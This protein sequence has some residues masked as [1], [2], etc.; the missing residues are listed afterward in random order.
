M[1]AIK[2]SCDTG[3]NP[4]D[5]AALDIGLDMHG[6]TISLPLRIVHDTGVFVAEGLAQLPPPLAGHL[7]LIQRVLVAFA[8]TR[9]Y[10]NQ[11]GSSPQGG[12]PDWFNPAPLLLY[13]VRS[14]GDEEYEL[15]FE[16][17]SG[18]NKVVVSKVISLQRGDFE[19]LGAETRASKELYHRLPLRPMNATSVALHKLRL[20]ASEAI[21]H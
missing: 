3:L 13:Q 20:A 18:P 7:E 10:A 16:D 4:S 5:D 6:G 8:E 11:P 19:T 14:V 1:E 9:F 17:V 15:S 21:R 2:I 12:A